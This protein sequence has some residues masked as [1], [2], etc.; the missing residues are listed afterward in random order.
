[1]L[2]ES[3]GHSQENECCA[4]FAVFARDLKSL[5]AAGGLLG[6]S[7]GNG[8]MKEGRKLLA[9]HEQPSL[10]GF[11]RWTETDRRADTVAD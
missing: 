7:R 11:T 2:S 8:A 5:V 10:T 6:F 1:M 4:Q 9:S 3:R